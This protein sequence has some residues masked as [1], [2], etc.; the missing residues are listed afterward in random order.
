[1]I[2]EF[3]DLIKRHLTRMPARET[4]LGPNEALNCDKWVCGSDEGSMN[5]GRAQL[6]FNYENPFSVGHQQSRFCVT[7]CVSVASMFEQK[8]DIF[9]TPTA[10][11]WRWWWPRCRG[12][13]CSIENLLLTNFKFYNNCH[14]ISANKRICSRCWTL[15]MRVSLPDAIFW[16]LQNG[17]QC[18]KILHWASVKNETLEDSSKVSLI[19]IQTLAHVYQLKFKIRSHT[20]DDAAESCVD[21]ND[22]SLQI[23]LVSN[24]LTSGINWV[25]ICHSRLSKLFESEEDD[26]QWKFPSSASIECDKT[27]FFNYFIC[28]KK[29]VD[30]T[31]HGKL[32]IEAKDCGT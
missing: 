19:S 23:R 22:F 9:L 29:C 18:H 6:A 26:V 27:F 3:D 31:S 17:I 25:T 28:I 21:P 16:A 30:K 15:Q 4:C 10:I 8:L 14:P 24:E 20:W 12:T 1:M 32:N 13:N 2:I 11:K 7:F 5:W